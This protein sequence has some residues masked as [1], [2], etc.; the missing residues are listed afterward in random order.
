MERSGPAD[1]ADGEAPIPGKSARDAGPACTPAPTV[2][3]PSQDSAAREHRC[4]SAGDVKNRGDASVSARR[5][6][7]EAQRALF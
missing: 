3:Q 6:A 7:E 4:R 5:S 1:V 2:N